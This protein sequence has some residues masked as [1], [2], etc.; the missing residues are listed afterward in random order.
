MLAALND[1]VEQP[2]ACRAIITEGAC[3][4]SGEASTWRVET[5]AHI[6]RDSYRAAACLLIDLGFF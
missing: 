1:P 4:F 2:T 6:Q 5:R 3:F